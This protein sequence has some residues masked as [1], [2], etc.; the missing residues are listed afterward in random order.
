MNTA[1][2]R[3]AASAPPVV[4]ALPPPAPFG[5]LTTAGRKPALSGALCSGNLLSCCKSL[6]GLGFL[7]RPVG[8]PSEEEPGEPLSE[9]PLRTPPTKR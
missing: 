9:E 4:G 1:Q 2:P 7:Q 8:G 6:W 3:A 5:A